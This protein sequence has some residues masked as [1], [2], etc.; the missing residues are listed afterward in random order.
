ML[1]NKSQPPKRTQG[2]F[3]LSVESHGS[4][5]ELSIY[6]FLRREGSPSLSAF[7]PR[8][9]SSA[10]VEIPDNVQRE[11]PS[12]RHSELRVLSVSFKIKK[13]TAQVINYSRQQNHCP[14]PL[15]N[16]VKLAAIR[17]LSQAYGINTVQLK[18]REE[19]IPMHVFEKLFLSH[20]Y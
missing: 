20:Y 3:Y 2:R 14:A 13:D 9:N 7:A 4:N 6:V 11:L 18:D 5:E 19:K 15:K 17:H 10:R 16:L 12:Y 8:P 1:I